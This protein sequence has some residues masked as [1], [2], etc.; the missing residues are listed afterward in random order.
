MS[1]NNQNNQTSCKYCEEL[2]KTCDYCSLTYDWMRNSHA[3]GSYYYEKTSGVI[4]GHTR[5]ADTMDSFWIASAISHPSVQEKYISEDH[6]KVKIEALIKKHNKF[7]AY[8]AY[9]QKKREEF[10]LAKMEKKEQSL[11]DSDNLQEK[12]RKNYFW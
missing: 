11:R 10:E 7:E 6:A 5:L 3:V 2:K 8:R 1:E 12:R 4:V 9:N